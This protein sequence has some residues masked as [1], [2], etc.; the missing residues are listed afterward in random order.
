MRPLAQRMTILLTLS[1]FPRKS[2]LILFSAPLFLT[3]HRHY[4]SMEFYR[5]AL[6][7]SFPS[8]NAD[9]AAPVFMFLTAFLL[10]GVIPILIVKYIFRERL[11]FYGVRS[12]N[13]RWGFLAV[14]VL[15]LII[16]F[17]LLL[18]SARMESF[19]AFYPFY[20]GA[21]T[22]PSTFIAYELMRGLFFYGAWE[23]FFR[24]FM[25]QG[26]RETFGDWNAIV[27]QIT[28]SCLRHIGFPEGEIFS[29]IVG[30]VLFGLLVIRTKSLVAAY[31][32][33]WGI[34]IF[35]DAF[36]VLGVCPS[37]EHDVEG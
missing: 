16:G 24:G 36:I 29:S 30:G 22:S 9:M 26:L 32:L 13:L 37:N 1:T 35:L 3:L 23:F 28:P 20:R 2:V 21:G 33:H 31:L 6:A 18:P 5:L 12:G 11:S 25:L 34:G 14:A 15:L 17:A 7:R 27:I 4:G 10:L 19:R 8:I